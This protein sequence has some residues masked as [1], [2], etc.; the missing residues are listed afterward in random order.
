MASHFGNLG[1]VGKCL[2]TRLKLRLAESAETMRPQIVQMRHAGSHSI[3]GIGE[4][5]CHK[6]D[7]GPKDH[8]NMRISHSG[9]EA[10]HKWDIKNHALYDP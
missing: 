1:F 4:T 3:L 5:P 10:Q 9:S 8:I 6:K 7:R 2:R